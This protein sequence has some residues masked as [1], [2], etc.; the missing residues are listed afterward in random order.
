M[1]R[2]ALFR[3][4]LWVVGVLAAYWVSTYFM[5]YTDDAYV[6]TDLIRV[7][8]R[9][10]GH[11]IKLAVADNQFVNKGDLL[12]IIDPEP[13]RLKLEN[14]KAEV[15][16]SK[17]MFKLLA[18]EVV[19]AR[20]EERKAKSKLAL[21]NVTEQR[22]RTLVKE[23]DIAE[24]EYDEVKAKLKAALDEHD[25]AVAAVAEAKEAL[26]AQK[27]VIAAAEAK[28]G[29][30][31]YDLRQTKVH[32]PA[33]GYVNALNV[34][35]GD[36][37]IVG[38]PVIGL[39]ADKGWRVIANYREYLARHIKPGQTVVIW[40]DGH[41]WRLYTAKVQGVARAV[42]RTPGK[43]RLLPYVEPKTNW[44][45]LARRFPVRIELSDL[46]PDLRLRKGADART[47]VVY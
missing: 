16:K 7:T 14:D 2:K 3:I 9:V 22:K 43:H 33:D 32:A 39:V 44:I 34:K 27:A 8:P 5:A 36:F 29:R 4:F 6:D 38:D 25:A 45:R 11:I 30:A 41:P 18:T 40:F 21:A 37:A 24:Q 13:F 42:S 35:P 20:A 47:L 10:S 15:N 28:L 46:P 1:S 12:F 17:A 19:S 31:E 26:T 23:G